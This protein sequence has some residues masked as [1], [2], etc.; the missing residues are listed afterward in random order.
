[1]EIVPHLEIE[2]R[3]GAVIYVYENVIEDADGYRK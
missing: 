3:D 2:Q 1:V